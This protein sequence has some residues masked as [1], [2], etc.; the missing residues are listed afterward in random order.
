[1]PCSCIGTKFINLITKI[2]WFTW[3]RGE[4][5]YNIIQ[6]QTSRNVI[7]HNLPQKKMHTNALYMLLKHIP[8][9]LNHGLAGFWFCKNLG[10][11]C[12]TS[13]PHSAPSPLSTTQRHAIE[14]FA[15]ER[16]TPNVRHRQ[17][18]EFLI[19]V[20]SKAS[21]TG[22]NPYWC[23]IQPLESDVLYRGV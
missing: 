1:M 19:D 13:K 2:A 20:L 11:P 8:T 23:L 5:K 14:W 17:V 4:I 22:E 18:T 15:G 7:Y 16:R 21:A 6:I 10:A 3:L 12:G 9:N